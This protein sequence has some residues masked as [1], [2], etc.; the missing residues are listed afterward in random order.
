[1]GDKINMSFSELLKQQNID[2]NDKEKVVLLQ[3][4]YQEGY[5]QGVN[6]KNPDYEYSLQYRSVVTRLLELFNKTINPICLEQLEKGLDV[7]DKFYK[8]NLME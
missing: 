2:L 1:M 8:E 3:K 4:F 7:M 6:D 5:M